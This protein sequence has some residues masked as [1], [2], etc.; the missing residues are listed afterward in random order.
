MAEAFAPT[1]AGVAVV[2][3]GVA[4]VDDAGGRPHHPVRLFLRPSPR[5]WVIRRLR[6]PA[7]VGPLRPQG[8][9][10]Q[11]QPATLSHLTRGTA[12]YLDAAYD[13]W[14]AGV[15]REAASLLGAETGDGGPFGG[16]VHGP[17]FVMVP[18]A[19]SIGVKT[20]YSSPASRM[21]TRAGAWARCTAAA[22]RSRSLA[23]G[24][25][26]VQPRPREAAALAA[27][28]I[29]R[30]VALSR[31]PPRGL[32]ADGATALG[33]WCTAIVRALDDD[34]HTA[35]QQLARCALL[36]AMR[37]APRWP[38]SQPT[39]GSS[40]SA[41]SLP[42]PWGGST[43]SPVTLMAGAPLALRPP[44]RR[45]GTLS[46]C[47]S[48]RKRGRTGAPPSAVMMR[49]L[50]RSALR[51]RSTPRATLGVSNGVPMTR[52]FRPRHGQG[53]WA[54]RRP[55]LCLTNSVEPPCPS[56]AARA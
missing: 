44:A 53:T 52:T 2:D 14:I 7:L 55:L 11:H 29:R 10:P 36:K 4:V 21:W 45:A 6:K 42:G 54:A 1:I 8:P 5:H 50:R 16:R 41:A 25:S 3:D 43:A 37:P 22:A 47:S 51:M 34:D 31:H 38:G 13:A 35:M 49:P 33:T 39:Y 27:A 28:A 24:G 20:L 17:R 9:L 18:A 26:D 40:G 56:P 12:E 30:L 48:R 19:G 15:E 32:D 23:R 46:R